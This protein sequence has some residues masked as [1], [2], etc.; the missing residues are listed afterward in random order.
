MLTSN[1]RFFTGLFRAASVTV[2]ILIFSLGFLSNASAHAEIVDSYPVAGSELS[3]GPSKITLTWS[4]EITTDKSQ[5]RIIDSLGEVQ[6]S[7]MSLENSNGRTIATLSVDEKLPNGSWSV[8]WKVVSADGHLVGGLIPF[9]VGV[10]DGGDLSAYSVDDSSIIT[11]SNSRLDRGVEAVTWIGLLIS[12]GLLLGGSYYFSLLMSLITIILVSSRI[13]AFEQEMGSFFTQ[14]GEAR[15]AI[16]VGLSAF[17]IFLGSLIKKKVSSFI[18]FGLII[19]SLQ[20]LFSGHHLDLLKDW[21]VLIA[22][23]AH[24]LHIFAGALWFTAVMAL[25]VNRTLSSVLRTRWLA[26]KAL[27]LLAVAGP[28]LALSL[29]IPAWGSSGF[30]WLVMLGIKTLLVLIAAVVGFVH[31]R[32]SSKSSEEISADLIDP[33]AWRNSLVLQ[34]VIFI[35]VLL[36]SAAL[37]TANPP[38]ID[39]RSSAPYSDEIDNGVR[40]EGNTAVSNIL[41]SGGYS[42]ELTYPTDLNSSQWELTF[43]SDEPAILPDSITVEAMNPGAGLSG[44]IIELS[45]TMNN[46]YIADAKL[47][48]AGSWHIHADFYI[49]QF[50]KEH[51]M[52][53]LEIK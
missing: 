6:D 25:S 2:I 38:V 40:I 19:F 44:I 50:T 32:K 17:I 41:F 14:I 18:I 43:N 33:R 36:V 29:I 11:S 48:I 52:I 3:E 27:F 53:K 22:S 47:P 15:A 39:K 51:G 30:D 5:I 45:K 9:T 12:A 1:I 10:L 4:E 37:T 42:A 20:G 16:F 7:E 46:N 35:S 8:T 13:L 49:D 24:F 26:T 21:L 34:I 28:L 23:T 31:H